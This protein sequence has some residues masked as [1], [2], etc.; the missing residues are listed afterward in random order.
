[1][2]DIEKRYYTFDEKTL[3]FTGSL[4]S[5]TQPQFSTEVSP[6]F[7]IDPTFDA[8]SNQWV[9]HN[10]NVPPLDPTKQPSLSAAMQMIGQVVAENAALKAENASLQKAQ[11]A[12]DTKAQQALTITGSLVAQMAALNKTTGGTN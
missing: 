2:S 3:A 1:M 12:T 10:N 7:L 4:T 9:E 6:D 11:A 5:T 8:K